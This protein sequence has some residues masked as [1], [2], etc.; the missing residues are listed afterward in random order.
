MTLPTDWGH[1]LAQNFLDAA[2]SCGATCAVRFVIPPGFKPTG[3]CMGDG[4]CTCRLSASVLEGF[5]RVKSGPCDTSRTARIELILE[6][7]AP[8]PGDSGDV[9]PVK[10]AG[11]AR[12]QSVLRWQILQGLY[13]WWKDG[14]L[15]GAATTNQIPGAGKCANFTPGSWELLDPEGTCLR[16]RMVWTFTEGLP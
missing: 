1:Q 6:V 14:T 8:I 3:G 12:D 10:A 13:K 11:L 16:F 7:C 2:V 9:D 5:V 4:G 15:A